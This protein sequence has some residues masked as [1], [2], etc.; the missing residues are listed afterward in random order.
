VLG[1][2]IFG[3]KCDASRLARSDCF[4][5]AVGLAAARNNVPAIYTYSYF[6]KEG[7]L[8]CMVSVVNGEDPAE[9]DLDWA[10][11][12]REAPNCLGHS[13]GRERISSD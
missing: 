2:D 9:P 6:A 7:G 8:P 4:D 12:E 11:C 10:E 3:T 5:S 13:S 1:H